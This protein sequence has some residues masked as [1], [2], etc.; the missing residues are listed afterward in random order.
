MRLAVALRGRGGHPRR[1]QPRGW[2]A[3]PRSVWNAR[4]SAGWPACCAAGEPV[5]RQLL[6]LDGSEFRQDPGIEN[7]LC[8][9]HGG[10]ALFGGDL[11]EIVLHGV[12]DAVG[13]F[14]HHALGDQPLPLAPAPGVLLGLPVVEHLDAVGAERVISEVER[15]GGIGAGAG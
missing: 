2:R 3:R 12:C 10:R 1:R 9:A 15:L 7:I 6:E 4:A 14:A 5:Q 11:G 8:P 13:A